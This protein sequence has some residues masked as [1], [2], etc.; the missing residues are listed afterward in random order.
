MNT[1]QKRLL[2]IAAAAA[3]VGCGT[4]REYSQAYETEFT[5][6]KKAIVVEGYKRRSDLMIDPADDTFP[7]IETRGEFAVRFMGV[8]R[9]GD[10][11]LQVITP[12]LKRTNVTVERAETDRVHVG[13]YGV[14]DVTVVVVD[15][16]DDLLTY[17]LQ[18][19]DG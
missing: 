16:T 17:R 4:Q 15:A 13:A 1:V 2:A 9:N 19:D 18:H 6:A 7:V 8:D 14:R 11:I 5:A 3:L 10:P 12:G